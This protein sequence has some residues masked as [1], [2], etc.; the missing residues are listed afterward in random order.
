MMIFPKKGCLVWVEL[1]GLICLAFGLM[2]IHNRLLADAGKEF[3]SPIEP[4]T[5]ILERIHLAGG[6]DHGYRLRPNRGE[7]RRDTGMAQCSGGFNGNP[8]R[9]CGRNP[10]LE[11]T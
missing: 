9:G 11:S 5:A 10:G 7:E 1:A 2:Y 8:V 3:R 6:T 4:K